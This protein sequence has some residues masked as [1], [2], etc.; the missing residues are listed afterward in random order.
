[1]HIF[2]FYLVNRK[3]RD[4]STRGQ[5]DKQKKTKDAITYTHIYLNDHIKIVEFF[6]FLF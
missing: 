1:M 6:L 4:A 5:S 2:E 3:Y